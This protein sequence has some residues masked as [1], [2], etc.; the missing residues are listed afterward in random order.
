MLQYF[1]GI[2]KVHIRKGTWGAFNMLFNVEVEANKSE[3]HLNYP[4][5]IKRRKR[6]GSSQ[7][8]KFQGP[9]ETKRR[10]EKEVNQVDRNK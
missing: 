1:C 3:V 7:E 2:S 6:L 10:V 8:I 9:E 5:D 4:V